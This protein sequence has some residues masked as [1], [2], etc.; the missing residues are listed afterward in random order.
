MIV[1]KRFCDICGKEAVETFQIP[2]KT[3]LMGQGSLAERP[4]VWLEGEICVKEQDL[5]EE[6]ANKFCNFWTLT[7]NELIKK[8][9]E[10]Y[11]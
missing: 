3:S 10:R 5:C 4:R 1:E 7:V 11:D 6:C 8:K 9:R 2:F